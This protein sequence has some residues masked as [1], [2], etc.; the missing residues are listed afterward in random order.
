MS[1]AAEPR[2]MARV[3]SWLSEIILALGYVGQGV[4][5][6]NG[7]VEG[8]DEVLRQK[9]WMYALRT[10]S[11]EIKRP[12]LRWRIRGSVSEMSRQCL[13]RGG[14]QRRLV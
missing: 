3:Y 8:G 12:K 10:V 2:K 11:F 1:I 14:A 6:T 4:G 7:L 13:A 5:G 9:R